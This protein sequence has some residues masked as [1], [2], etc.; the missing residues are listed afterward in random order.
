MF[1][2]IL[3]LFS[4]LLFLYLLFRFIIIVV[5]IIVIVIVFI[6]V[7]TILLSVRYFGGNG[8]VFFLIYILFGCLG[9]CIGYNTLF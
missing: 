6:I 2:F 3:L 5:I 8:Y 7:I 1:H 9:F 4:L